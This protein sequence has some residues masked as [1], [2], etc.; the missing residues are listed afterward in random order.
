MVAGI[1]TAC[2]TPK[3]LHDDEPTI[4]S[5]KGRRESVEKDPMARVDPDRAIAAYRAFAKAAPDAPQRP[6]VLRRLGDLEMEKVEARIAEGRAAGTKADWQEAVRQYQALL[7]EHPNATGHDRV[8]YQLARAHEQGGDLDDALVVL[9]RL[10]AQF[11]SS[12]HLGEAQFRRGELLF[13]T[14][15][16][17]KAEDAYAKVLAQPDAASLHERARS[18]RGWSQFKQARLD[19][20][21]GSFFAVLDAKL[22]PVDRD[23]NA[24]IALADVLTLS[25]AD[26][27]LVED[28]FRVMGLALQNVQGAGG[29]AAHIT[30]NVRRGYEFR[31][32]D[33]L[34][35]L[36]LK[37]ERWKD[38]ADTLSAFTR[39]A[40]LHVHAPA[41]QAKVIEIYADAGFATLALQAKKDHVQHYG[42]GSDYQRRQPQVWARQAQPLVK[43]HLVELA[44]HHHALAQKGKAKDDVDEAQRWYRAL[45]EGF[46]DDA[47]APDHRFLLAELLH[48]DGRLADAAVEFEHVAY[49]ASEKVAYGHAQH[50]R[51]ADAGYAAVLDRLE[52]AK[53]TDAASREPMQRTA[54][55]AQV[56]FAD[57]FPSDARAAAVLTH[58]TQT[59]HD[60][61]D[62]AGAGALAQRV[63]DLVP[64]AQPEHRR[65]AL[66]VLA[67]SAFEAGDFTAAEQRYAALLPLMPQDAARAEMVERHAAAIYQQG[68]AARAAGQLGDAARHFARVADAAPQSAVRANAQFDA[69]ATMIAAK[70]WDGAAR[71]LED[72]RTRYATHPLAA[73]V[74]ARLVVVYT[75][76]SRWRDAA[77]EY[78]RL[79][80]KASSSAALDA[81]WHAAQLYDKAVA[82][83]GDG[84]AT[85]AAIRAYERFAALPGADLPRWVEAQSRLV[86]AARAEGRD[87]HALTLAQALVRT[88]ATDAAAR[89]P[90]TR[91]LASRAAL[92]ATQPALEAYR[93]VALIE[94]LKKQLATKKARMQDVLD[95]YARVSDYGAAEAV[96]AATFHTAELYRDFGRALI[97]S[98][99]PKKLSKLEREQYDVMLEEQ[100][101]PFEE[102]AIELHE[103]NAR[104]A[105][106][107]LYDASVKSSYAA[108]RQL[109]PG[110]WARDERAAGTVEAPAALE[111]VT[112]VQPPQAAAFDRLGVAQRR[113]GDFQ[114]ARAA[115]ER[116]L[117]IDPAHASAALNL[118]VLHDLYLGDA[119]RAAELYARYLTLTPAGDGAVTKW[120]AEVKQRKAPVAAAPASTATT[121]T[122]ASAGLRQDAR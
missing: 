95:A 35:A 56:R 57:A 97:G 110:R 60:L 6:E 19:E 10:V 25:R 53:R 1:L 40:P 11:P 105:A 111:A 27:E 43:T 92:I 74:P 3:N 45:L 44:R 120:L 23:G 104:R 88:E 58:A 69:A 114:A 89:S 20:A 14:R 78:E 96:T 5:L 22:G 31:V 119:P 2:G 90:R 77:G 81:Q 66:T 113:A 33:Q 100:A 9:D 26:R 36:Y 70:D 41:M 8:L 46:P 39:R 118:A 51:A 52:L 64:A 13:T 28:T 34:A 68:E 80:A 91:L 121:S 18:M 37:Q 122:A 115:Y 16:Y 12:A 84:G 32:Y 93:K 65:V 107:G 38:A 102:K 117:E 75:E 103:A 62:T 71:Q 24:P 15:A 54:V 109:R 86:D 108:L 72:F 98:Q 87:A 82:K 101:F 42:V 47:A 106:S 85:V 99:R 79:A 61:R 21:I 67:H 59:L 50:P 30:T 73:D 48:D 94:P 49:G 55:N 17:A 7:K 4:A 29:I 116:A 63:L 112:Q 83:G 76:Q